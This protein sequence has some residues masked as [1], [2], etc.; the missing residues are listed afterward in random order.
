MISAMRGY[1]QLHFSP[2]MLNILDIF[3]PDPERSFDGV[4]YCW[5]VAHTDGRALLLLRHALPSLSGDALTKA[6][7]L[8]SMLDDRSRWIADDTRSEVLGS[9]RWSA[10]EVFYLVRET[11]RSCELL[12]LL[13]QDPGLVEIVL[14]SIDLAVSQGD[15][16][17]A[18]LLWILQRH[19]PGSCP[20]GDDAVLIRHPELLRS[21]RVQAELDRQN[22]VDE[23]WNI[24]LG[25]RCGECGASFAE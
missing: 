23:F 21:P 6:I 12:P 24:P 9:F 11:G 15:L 7:D 17:C 2:R 3:S 8:L 19:L 16:D 14:R 20:T 1:T 5:V 22:D 25:S 13:A 18:F 4:L 10:Q